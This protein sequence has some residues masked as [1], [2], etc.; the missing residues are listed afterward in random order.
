MRVHTRHPNYFMH[1]PGPIYYLWA[2]HYLSLSQRKYRDGQIYFLWAGDNY[3]LPRNFA[4]PRPLLA[5]VD[6]VH[7][8]M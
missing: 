7:F 1:D 4:L 5:I 2:R 8:T 6:S 3:V